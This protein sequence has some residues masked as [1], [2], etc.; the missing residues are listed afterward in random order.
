MSTSNPIP[1]RV[2]NKKVYVWDIDGK[3][4]ALFVGGGPSDLTSHRHRQAAFTPHLW[5]LGW[6]TSTSIAAECILRRASVAHARGGGPP[7]RKG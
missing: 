2:S 4:T 6:D 7:R 3:I 1:L 5:C